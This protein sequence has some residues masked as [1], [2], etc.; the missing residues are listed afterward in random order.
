VGAGLEL[1]DE[2]LQQGL[3]VAPSAN[4]ESQSPWHT[5]SIISQTRQAAALADS[6][7]RHGGASLCGTYSRAARVAPIGDQAAEVSSTGVDDALGC[8]RYAVPARK[9]PIEP[10]RVIRGVD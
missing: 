1:V 2:A 7:C 4:I 5:S 6:C 10:R 8:T 3:G 9:R